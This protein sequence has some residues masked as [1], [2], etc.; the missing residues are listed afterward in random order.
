MKFALILLILSMAIL[1]ECKKDNIQSG[2]NM[3][4]SKAVYSEKKRVGDLQFSLAA[5]ILKKGLHNNINYLNDN[6]SIDYE[7]RNAGDKSFVI[8]NR[9]HFGFDD[10]KNV[11]YVE[12]Q[13]DGNIEI[14]QKAFVEPRDKQCP[15]RLIPIVPQGSLLKAKQTMKEQVDLELPPKLKSP[16]ADCLPIVVMPAEIKQAR[17]CVGAAEVLDRA[18]VRISAD[19]IVQGR[20]GLSEQQLLCSNIIELR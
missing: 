10:G 12:P 17:F 9:G 6:L 18:K 4:D 11:V 3:Q 20:D 7:I 8:Y 5:K 19:G 15:A 1:S 2:N 16:Y 13:P 14:S